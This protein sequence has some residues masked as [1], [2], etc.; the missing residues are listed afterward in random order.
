[1]AEKDK[2]EPFVA[3]DIGSFSLKF[4]HVLPGDDGKPVLKA[5]AHMRI[6]PFVHELKPEDREKMSREDVENDAIAKLQK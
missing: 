5:L 2:F 1:M 3:V 6:P 4:V